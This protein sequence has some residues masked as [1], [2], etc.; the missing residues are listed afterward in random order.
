MM[1][2]FWTGHLVLSRTWKVWFMIASEFTVKKQYWGN[3]RHLRIFV[4]QIND[5]IIPWAQLN[6]A[7]LHFLTAHF[8]TL[9]D[10]RQSNNSMW[11]HENP[12]SV[13][14]F[15]HDHSTREK[16]LRMSLYFHLDNEQDKLSIPG[17]HFIDLLHQVK[18]KSWVT[19]CKR[20]VTSTWSEEAFSNV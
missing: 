7:E 20:W 2:C 16:S 5:H 13:Q 19:L 15:C 14:S 3:Y 4:I 10:L 9:I 11:W 6:P 12:A 8:E 1:N 17:L 18:V